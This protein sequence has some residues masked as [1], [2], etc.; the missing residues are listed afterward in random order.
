MIRMRKIPVAN[1]GV[2]ENTIPPIERIRSLRLPSFSPAIIPSIRA[3]GIT[4]TKAVTVRTR[5]FRKRTKILLE[6][7]RP[8]LREMPG[9]PRI[10]PF[11]RGIYSTGAPVVSIQP[12]PTMN[13]QLFRADPLSHRTAWF[14]VSTPQK[15]TPSF[16]CVF[17]LLLSRYFV[18]VP[19]GLR[20]RATRLSP[21][22]FHRK[23]SPSSPTAHHSSKPSLEVIRLRG[24]PTSRFAHQSL[25][26]SQYRYR[27]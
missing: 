5:E 1:S 3:R 14:C 9:S 26:T 15:P 11:F 17:H 19:S 20:L 27:T 7:G 18:M 25:P 10:S 24:I 12:V 16:V 21:S 22:N 8:V 23:G 13:V 2:T 6:T 4:M